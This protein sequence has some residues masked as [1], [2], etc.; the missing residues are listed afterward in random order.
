MKTLN[1]KFPSFTLRSG[2]LCLND[3][4]R[5]IRIEIWDYSSWYSIQQKKIFFNFFRRADSLI[6]RLD[7]SINKLN[8]SKNHSLLNTEKGKSQE[9]GNLLVERILLEPCYTFL[10]Y[11]S[12]G[13]QISLLVAIDF[14]GKLTK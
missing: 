7:T 2:N 10:D 12:G 4:D 9:A 14:T 1:P 8:K 11:I 3:Y 13:H 5:T 6:G